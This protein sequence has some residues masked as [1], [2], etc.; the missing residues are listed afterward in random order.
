MAHASRSERLEDERNPSPSAL[1]HAYQELRQLVDFLPQ[2]VIV[3]DAKGN[4]I[5]ANQM[6]DAEP[7][8][9]EPCLGGA[10]FDITR[11]DRVYMRKLRVKA[12]THTTS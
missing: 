2:H 5:Q 12:P 9:R 3:L 11:G 4:L 8:D 1:R 6:S 7:E 10:N